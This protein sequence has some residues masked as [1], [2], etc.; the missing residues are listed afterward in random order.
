MFQPT[1]GLQVAQHDAWLE[2]MRKE[3][4]PEIG[5]V[6]KVR[7]RG[8]WRLGLVSRMAALAQR[9]GSRRRRDV[10]KAPDV[11]AQAAAPKIQAKGLAR[12]T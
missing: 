10:S 7:Q 11:P 2:E 5:R 3:P 9:V 12:H 8:R 4:S 6:V 1:T